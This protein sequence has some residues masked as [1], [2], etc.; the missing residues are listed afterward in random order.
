MILLDFRECWDSSTNT[1]YGQVADGDEDHAYWG[2][3][4]DYSETKAVY[5]IDPSNPG[6]DLAA[7]TAVYIF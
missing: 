3:P 6:T 1:L 7:E 2:R 5:Y 4:E